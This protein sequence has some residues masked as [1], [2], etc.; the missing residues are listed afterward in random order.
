MK[1]KKVIEL[2]IVSLLFSII[3][4][5]TKAG[6]TYTISFILVFGVFDLLVLSFIK[7]KLEETYGKSRAVNMFV[8][9]FGLVVLLVFILIF[10]GF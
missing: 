9:G 3:G 10:L 7:R 5:L 4:F 6:L 8:Y 2:F 1:S